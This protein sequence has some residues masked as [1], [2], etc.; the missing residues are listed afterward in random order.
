MES[1]PARQKQAGTARAGV[2]GEIMCRHGT[3]HAGT[4]L[5]FKVWTI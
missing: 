3:R 5:Y 4:E 2:P 1:L